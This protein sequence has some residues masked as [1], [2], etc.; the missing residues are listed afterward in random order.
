MLVTGLSRWKKRSVVDMGKIEAQYYGEG[1]GRRWRCGNPR[2]DSS[3]MGMVNGGWGCLHPR[4]FEDG[5]IVR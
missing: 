3:G 2:C 5:F 1:D 4:R